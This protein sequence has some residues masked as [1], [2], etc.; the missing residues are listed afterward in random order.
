MRALSTLALLAVLSSCAALPEPPAGGFDPAVYEGRP[1]RARIVNAGGQLLVNTSRPAH[2]AIFEIVPGRGVGL[3]YPAFRGENNYLPAGLNSVF[4]SRS[5]LYYTYFQPSPGRSGPRYLYMIA[6]DA[7]LRL[8]GLVSAPGALRRDL[9]M[10]RFAAYSPYGLME[11]LADMVLAYGAAGDWTE[12]V[13]AVWDNRVYDTESYAASQWVR[14]QCADGRIIEGPAY[15]VYGACDR[16]P[17]NGVPPLR[18]EPGQPDDSTRAKPPTRRRPEPREP[19]TGDDRGRQAAPAVQPIPEPEPARR[20]GV[21]VRER[22]EEPR[23]ADETPRERARDRQD[24]HAPRAER[25]SAPADRGSEPRVERRS[26]PR[27]EPR[28]ESRPEPRSE[29]RA[30][31]PRAETPRSETPPSEARGRVDPR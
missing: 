14:V 21:R 24:D 9:G 18:E 19:V 12:D 29:P 28:V 20:P 3:L 23:S 10:A 2:V 5:R 25:P 11:D 30:E 7:P 22:I 17:R 1:L 15:Y 13:Y 27:R 31:T 6:S 26:E 16:E 4:L 8:S